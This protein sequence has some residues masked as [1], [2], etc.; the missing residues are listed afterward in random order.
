MAVDREC[1]PRSLVVLH[2]LIVALVIGQF[3]SADGMEDFFR[4]ADDSGIAPG[5]PGPGLALAH[6]GF[7][8]T[9]LALVIVRFIVRMASRV[10][11]PPR[12]L[13]PLLQL[14]A[15]LT[16]YGLYA[17]LVLTPLSGAAAI[18]ITPEAG[19]V[20]EIMKN[21]LLALAAAHVA[22]A[23]MHLVVLRDGVFWRMV[24]VGRR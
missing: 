7:G 2:W 23:L 1:Y 16:H 4:D 19:D 17:A 20:H 11:P 18:L 6:A 21:V 22:G 3:L 8:A 15:R 9:I 10:P 5:L 12:D 14:A 24:P 13:H